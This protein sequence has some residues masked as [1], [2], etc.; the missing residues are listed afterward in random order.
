MRV[1][2]YASIDNA[3]FAYLSFFVMH[4]SVSEL[5]NSNAIDSC[6]AANIPRVVT[7]ISYQDGK[8]QPN[9]RI[10]MGY[11]KGPSRKYPSPNNVGSAIRN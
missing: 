4:K 3:Q 10:S 9:F 2:R 1:L 8:L 5:V 7:S 11:N 6:R